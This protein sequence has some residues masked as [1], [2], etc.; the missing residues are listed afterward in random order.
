MK[1]LDK[2]DF[3]KD[4]VLVVHVDRDTVTAPE[5][6]R[7]SLRVE[8]AEMLLGKCSTSTTAR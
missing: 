8:K 4:S 5:R 6:L 2:F 3:H 1:D 7:A